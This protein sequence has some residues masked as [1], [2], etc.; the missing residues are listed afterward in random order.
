MNFLLIGQTSY[1][2]GLADF[3]FTHCVII[4]HTNVKW[5]LKIKYQAIC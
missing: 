4:Q 5:S 3:V 2:D 1:P